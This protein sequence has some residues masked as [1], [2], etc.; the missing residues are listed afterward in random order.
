M[1]IRAPAGLHAAAKRAHRGRSDLAPAAQASAQFERRHTIVATALHTPVH[2]YGSLKVTALPIR[3]HGAQDVLNASRGR[4]HQRRRHRDGRRCGRR[5]RARLHP[6]HAATARPAADAGSA[7][8][9]TP[10][11][12]SVNCDATPTGGLRGRRGRLRRRVVRSRRRIR[13][14]LTCHISGGSLHRHIADDAAA[15]GR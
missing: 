12:R 8:L 7:R 11:R 14:S 2:S 4:S 13:G 3:R 15:F 1:K 9:A 10:C 5:L 6:S